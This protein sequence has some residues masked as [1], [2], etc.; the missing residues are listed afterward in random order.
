MRREAE[1]STHDVAS[2]VLDLLQIASDPET[3]FDR[4]VQDFLMSGCELFD[5]ETGILAQVEGDVVYLDPPY[6]GTTSY[7]REY[8]VLDDLLEG[9]KRPTS[10]FSRS[11]DLLTDLFK[12]CE[13]IPIWLLSLNNAVLDQEELEELVH[14]HRR[15]VTCLAI[16]YR[17][18]TS[19]A[20]EK[21]NEENREYIVLAT[22]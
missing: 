16:P 9:E 18:L 4:K 14:R 19:I 22:N 7:E 1:G 12:A 20:S 6:P 11:A 3:S 15:H 5:L 8:A 13:H 21:K 2:F 10:G 17:H